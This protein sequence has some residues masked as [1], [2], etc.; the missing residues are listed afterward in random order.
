M[1]AAAAYS[2]RHP[3]IG[4]GIG[5][6]VLELNKIRGPA[7]VRVHNVYLQYSMDLG[8]PGLILF[9]LLLYGALKACRRACLIAAREV[10]QGDLYFMA[11]AIG[12]SLVGFAVAAMFYP[13]GYSFDFFYFAGLAV[14]AKIMASGLTTRNRL[15]PDPGS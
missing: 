5:M 9:L 12:V 2:L 4:A 15:D 14:A 3:I 11:E 7:W 8:W 13:N 1:K 6:S 10:G